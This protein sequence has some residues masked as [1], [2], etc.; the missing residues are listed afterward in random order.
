MVHVPDGAET[1]AA[2]SLWL[3]V[4]TGQRQ[5]E[6]AEQEEQDEEEGEATL[7]LAQGGWATWRN[8]PSLSRSGQG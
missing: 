1:P 3:L 4:G 2:R 6:Q 8:T 7:R 5:E